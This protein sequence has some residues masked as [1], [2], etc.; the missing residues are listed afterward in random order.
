MVGGVGFEAKQQ[1]S[2]K[3]VAVVT[4]EQANKEQPVKTSTA[5]KS[6]C[7]ILQKK[8]KFWLTGIFWLLNVE[9]NM[10][11]RYHMFR[12]NWDSDFFIF[13]IWKGILP[14]L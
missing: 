1:D 11:Q 6:G 10:L 9:K 14:K 5:V 2:Q 4:V 3:P 7:F 12:T 13:D 8:Y